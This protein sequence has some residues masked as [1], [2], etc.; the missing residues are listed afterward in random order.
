MSL[1]SA[2]A[3]ISWA[4]QIIAAAILAYAGIAKL[5]A[6]PDP[7]KL[8]TLLGAEPGGRILVG[9]L[10]VTAAMLLLWQRT[11]MIGGGLAIFLMLGA[12]STHLFKIGIAIDGNPTFFIL[13][14]VVLVA[15]A[16]T[17]FLRTRA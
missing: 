1:P 9:C 14:C 8:F 12:I 10:E 11:A 16:T 3:G 2:R 4:I 6:A 7:V 17:I 5:V 13:A 15:G